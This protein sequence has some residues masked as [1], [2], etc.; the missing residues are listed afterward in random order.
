MWPLQ[1]G[2]VCSTFSRRK[3][4]LPKEPPLGLTK[5]FTQDR[6]K[7]IQWQAFLR[8][9]ALEALLLEDTVTYLADFLMPVANAASSG[10]S[11]TLFWNAGGPWVADEA[12]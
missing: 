4:D 9:N 10:T 6:Q 5:V 8:K 12:N 11:F 3:T 7:Q 2:D 1:R